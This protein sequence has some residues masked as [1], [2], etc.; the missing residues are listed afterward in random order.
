MAGCFF[1]L[2]HHASAALYNA[3]GL[4]GH[5]DQSGNPVYTSGGYNNG[6]NPQGLWWPAGIALDF[7]SHRLFLSDNINMRILVFQLDA[8][9]NLTTTTPSHVLGVPDLYA[10]RRSGVALTTASNTWN[11]SGLAYDPV[12]QRLFEAENGNVRV[13]VFN[14]ATSTIANGENADYVLGQP[15]F[16]SDVSATTQSGFNYTASVAYDVANTRLFVLDN[17]NN[18]VL[19]FNVATSTIA[20]GE[21]ASYVLGQPNF[22][23]SVGTTT[24]SGL[25]TNPQNFDIPGLAYDATNTRLF[26]ADNNNNRVMVFN[27]ATST[28]TNGENAINVLG[29]TNFTSS[30]AATTQNGFNYPTGL[31]YDASGNRLFVNDYVNSR[32]MVFDITSST[33]TNGENAINVLGQTN[34]ISSST[35]VTQSG[36]PSPSDALFYDDTNGNLFVGETEFTE[37]LNGVDRVMVFHA[38][39]STITNGENAYALL[40]HVDQNGNPLWTIAGLNNGPNAQGFNFQSSLALDTLSHRLFVLDANN[41]R[42][43]VFPLDANN[44][45]TTMTASYV[46][47]QPDFTSR[48]DATTTQS[49]FN[50]ITTHDIPPGLAY[51]PTDLTDLLYQ[52]DC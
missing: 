24:Q 44:D 32:T 31:A 18:R 7:Q 46:L 5:A 16:T 50:V 3:S 22:T 10:F 41:N 40:G 2:P 52:V 27:V 28:I 39:T 21:N 38:A 8:N 11:P 9:N 17:G 49:G 1:V 19:V 14:V 15:N 45:L 48:N 51:D 34:F 35:A 25:H 12:N 43:L 30:T 4:L 6:P 37:T 13:L 29:Q 42:V 36:L 26:V 33:I 47:G 23:S 20:N